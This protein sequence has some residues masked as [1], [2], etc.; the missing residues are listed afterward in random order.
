MLQD[1]VYRADIA[2]QMKVH[3]GGDQEGIA[4]SGGGAKPTDKLSHDMGHC[5]DSIT[6]SHDM[7]PL[8]LR[9][10]VGDL[11]LPKRV[12]EFRGS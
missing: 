5:N 7:E 9:R 1:G 6:R 10:G 2:A 11:E 3:N 8:S 4:P 12:L